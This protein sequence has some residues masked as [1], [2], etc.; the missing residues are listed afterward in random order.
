[1][2]AQNSLRQWMDLA[3][4]ARLYLHALLAF[5]MMLA[6]TGCYTLPPPQE[7][8][9]VGE[10]VGFTTDDVFFFRLRLDPGGTGLCARVFLDEQPSLLSVSK[11][12]LT[13]RTIRIHADPLDADTWP[14]NMIG[15]TSGGTTLRLRA[16]SSDDETKWARDLE[17]KRESR[18]LRAMDKTQRAMNR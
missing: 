6:M 11:W 17:F 15:E 13:D 5:A 18:L 14:F 4:H 16:S 9:L 3:A 12:T 10:W 1:M 8:H 7:E 2:R